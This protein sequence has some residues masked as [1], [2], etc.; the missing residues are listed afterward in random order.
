MHEQIDALKN[1]YIICGVGRVGGNVAH[2]LAVTGRPFVAVED[3]AP[4]VD[5]FKGKFPNVPCLHGDSS[6]DSVLDRAGLKRAVGL[7]AVTGDDSKNLLITL[8]AKQVNPAIRVV[9]RCHEIRNMDKLRRVGADAIVSPD[10][11][12]GMRIASSMI[13]PVV[14]GFL[15]EMLR[16][17]TSLRVEEIRVP[18]SAAPRTVAALAPGSREYILLAV[19]SSEGWEFN[20]AADREVVAGEVLVAMCT[21]NGRAALEKRVGT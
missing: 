8:T 10:F 2:E 14:V 4:A 1:H 9:A 19:K 12:G 13:R 21:P 6:D 17:D 15:D 20:P 5:A 11:T 3:A 16:S 18:E 7:F